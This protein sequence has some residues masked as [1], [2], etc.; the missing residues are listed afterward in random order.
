[1]PS[2]SA[3]ETIGVRHQLEGVDREWIETSSARTATYSHLRPGSYAMRV[4]ARNGYGIWNKDGAALRFTIAPA[5]WQTVW[6]GA[7]A[8]LLFSAAVASGARSWAQRK[9]SRKLERLEREHALEKERTRIARDLH[10]DLGGGLIE[11]GLIADRLAVTASPEASAPLHVLAA[12]TRRLGAELASII[13]AVNAKNESLD[14]LAHFIKLYS[15]RLFRNSPMECVVTGAESIAGLPLSPDTHH[16]L[17]AIAK[18]AVNNVLKHSRATHVSIDLRQ[19]GDLFELSVEDDGVGFSVD[20]AEVKEGNG[21]Q[22][23]RARASEIGGSL[24]IDSGQD[25]GTI[26]VLTYRWGLKP[27]APL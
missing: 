4:I 19:I 26:V 7:G 12:R 16:H 15:R 22:N 11:L 18:E 9:M 2:F 21:L 24:K 8:L 10:D 20:G 25:R 3:P 17:L 14:R 27:P 13:W 6:A 5:W 23:M 1:V